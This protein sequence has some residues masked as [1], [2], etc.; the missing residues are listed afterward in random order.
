MAT[1]RDLELA[2]DVAFILATDPGPI[3]NVAAR[4]GLSRSRVCKALHNAGRS[5]LVE[6]MTRLAPG[7]ARGWTCGSS[8]CHDC[9][10]LRQRR[11]RNRL[12]AA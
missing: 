5:D 2:E 12:K 11:H 6:R 7:R 1:A 9:G 8:S 3:A 4:L 10:R